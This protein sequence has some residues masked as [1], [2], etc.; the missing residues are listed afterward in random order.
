MEKVF[1]K[2]LKDFLKDLILSFPED[3][4]LKVITSGLN[5]AII[6]DS[7]NKMINTF[8]SSLNQFESFIF[9]RDPLFF[10]TN[11]TYF[12]SGTHQFK[13]FTKLNELQVDLSE[14]NKT[15]VWDYIRLIYNISSNLHTLS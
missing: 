6:D 7:D 1:Y 10:K 8:Y 12:K 13:F 2:T 3:E 4:E 14:N 11:T 15:K 9:N 5:I